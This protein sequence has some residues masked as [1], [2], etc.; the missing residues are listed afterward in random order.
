MLVLSD[1]EDDGASLAAPPAV[2]RQSDLSDD[3]GCY[4]TER[5]ASTQANDWQMYSNHELENDI[6]SPVDTRLSIGNSCMDPTTASLREA[7]VV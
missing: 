5:D 4:V 6:F 3:P 7:R 2:I 1:A